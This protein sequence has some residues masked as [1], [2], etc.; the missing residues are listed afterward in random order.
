M[1]QSYYV[2][3]EDHKEMIHVGQSSW[4]D[5]LN[6]YSREANCMSGLSSFLQKHFL[7]DN[8]F[9]WENAKTQDGYY[10]EIDWFG[11]PIVE[12]YDE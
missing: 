8:R 11:E 9:V 4:K 5:G 1:S 6:F 3:C 2:V 12:D 7:C 10:T